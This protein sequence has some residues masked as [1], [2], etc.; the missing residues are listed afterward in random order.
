[1]RSLRFFAMSI[2]LV[3]A[4][5]VAGLAQAPA[6]GFKVAVINTAR[7]YDDTAG[8]TITESSGS[9]TVQEAG[10][11]SDSYDVILDSQPEADC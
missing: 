11:T 3:S 8:I 5:A 10:T 2:L 6:A 1:M 9:T 4:F 7:F